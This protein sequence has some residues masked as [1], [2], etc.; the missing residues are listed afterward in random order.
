MI[1]GVNWSIATGLLVLVWAA[2]SV[3]VMVNLAAG[4]AE[5]RGNLPADELMLQVFAVP[6]TRQPPAEASVTVAASASDGRATFCRAWGPFD[7]AAEADATAAALGIAAGSYQVLE[8]PAA[9]RVD[10]LV[11]VHS[12]GPR[13]RALQIRQELADHGID[14]YL[15]QPGEAGYAL[16]VGVFRYLGRAESHQRRLLGLGYDAVIE[17]LEQGSSRYRL[18]AE[19]PAELDV[20]NTDAGACDEIAAHQRFL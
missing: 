2:N 11:R 17:S 15:L 8:D 1:P 3:F 19:V 13:E 7:S 12:D 9:D 4:H 6:A 18:V 20:K 5:P 16:A 14:S 10:L